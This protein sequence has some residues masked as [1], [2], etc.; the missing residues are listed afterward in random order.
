MSARRFGVAGFD[1]FIVLHGF[2]TATLRT[3]DNL[4]D[5]ADA[6]VSVALISVGEMCQERQA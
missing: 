5:A 6:V 4:I 2:F 3:F 1:D